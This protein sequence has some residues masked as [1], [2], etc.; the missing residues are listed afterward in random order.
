MLNNFQ[1]TI[2][3]EI[4]FKGKGIH[5]GLE[6]NV[7]LRPSESNTGIVFVRSDLSNSKKKNRIEAIAPNV[8][9]TYFC[10]ELSNSDG[11]SVLTVEHLMAALAGARI[12]NIEVCIDGAEVPI[13]D[14]SSIKFI[15][16]IDKT[17]IVNL[18]KQSKFIKILKPIEIVKD[19]SVARFM[20]SDKSIIEA[21]INFEH[22]EIG[23]QNIAF[24]FTPKVFRDQIASARTF[25]FLSQAEK[26]NS[27]GYGLG[28]NLSN[29]IVLTEKNIMNYEGLN[30]K[31]EFVKHKALDICG[32]LMLSGYNI[33]GKYQS[34]RGGHCLNHKALTSLFKEKDSW[35]I[36]DGIDNFFDMETE[37]LISNTKV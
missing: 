35:K 17:G 25:G 9:S 8:S 3:N 29:T 27:V 7:I 21:E 33:I 24:E 11:V 36:V 19:E 30:S 12:D 20:P 23:R 15:E 32:D 37:K 14:G 2:A 26:L 31:D 5:T 10:T 22:K 18:D 1:T 4:R 16:L 34:V 13:M 28:V 6:A